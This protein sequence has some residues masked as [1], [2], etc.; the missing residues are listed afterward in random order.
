[1]QS[2]ERKNEPPV[3]SNKLPSSF[4]RVLDEF[5]TINNELDV[6]ISNR[7]IVQNVDE[8]FLK[9]RLKGAVITH[10]ADADEK[11]K[12]QKNFPACVKA[13]KRVRSPFLNNLF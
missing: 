5:S 6:K 10:T 7:K 4:T 2:Y 12:V 13:L 11:E 8:E 3:D 9:Y 1:M